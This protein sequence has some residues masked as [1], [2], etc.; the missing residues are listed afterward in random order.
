MKK[1][2]LT[3]LNE[4]ER[5]MNEFER[6]LVKN[7]VDRSKEFFLRGQLISR[8]VNADSRS[9]TLIIISNLKNAVFR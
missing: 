7:H 2:K 1:E 3:N 8:N 5:Q 9:I 4:V 6:S